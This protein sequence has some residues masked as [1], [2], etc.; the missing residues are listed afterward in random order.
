[1]RHRLSDVFGIANDVNIASYVDRGRLDSKLEYL[2]GADR[3]LAIHGDS[4]QGKSWLRSNALPEAET[5]LVQ[6]TIE[7]TPESVLTSALGQL[8]I[9]ADISRT[10]SHELQGRLGLSVKGGIGAKVLA[11]VGLDVVAE[12]T[13]AKSGETAAEPVGQTPA[14]LSWVARILVASEMRLVVEDFHYLSEQSQKDWAYMLKALGEYGVYPIMVGIWPQDHLLTYYNGDLDGRVE[15][16]H[17]SWSEEELLEVLEK[18]TEAL[19]CT[20]DEPL[21]NSIVRDSYGNVGLL[22]RLAERTCLMAGVTGTSADRVDIFLDATY[23]DATTD[24]AEGMQGRFQAFADNFV[25]GMRR[26]P[27]GLEVYRHLLQTVTESEDQ[28]L[29]KGIDSADLLAKITA[30]GDDANIR[31]SDL[32]QALD[33]VDRL[34]AKINIHPPVLT[35]NR[36]SRKIFL[37]DRAF[38]FYRRFGTQ[39]WPWA[40]GESLENDLAEQ[41]P[42]DFEDFHRDDTAGLASE[43]RG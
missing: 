23:T 20:F 18:G 6:C 26:M 2:L 32:T 34:Q 4:K 30:H 35:Y 42:L 39:D 38:L 17:L 10:R 22:Q 12:G 7:A 28:S 8:G 14:D 5:L 15:D 1:M 3:H 13:A 41:E 33:R 37:G 9:W 29:L 11:K 21:R 16:L 40:K 24:V 27:Q 25:R 36:A 31:A 43:W 19:N